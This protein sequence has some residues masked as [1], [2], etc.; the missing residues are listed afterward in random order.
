MAYHQVQVDDEVFE[1]VKASA[2]PLEDTFNTALKRILL[3]NVNE[4]PARVRNE[5]TNNNHVCVTIPS[6]PV[7][8]P[9]ALQQILSVVYLVRKLGHSRTKA[10]QIVARRLNVAPQTVQ[11]KYCRQLQISSADFDKILHQDTMNNLRDVLNEKFTQNSELI[12]ETI[13]AY[14]K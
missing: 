12:E 5:M 6:F 13:N 8:T 11:D 7:G 10:T 4:G 14:R 3:P 9:Q 2:R 1:L